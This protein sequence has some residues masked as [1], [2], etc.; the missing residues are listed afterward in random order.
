L[1][2]AKLIEDSL[3]NSDWITIF[4]LGNNDRTYTELPEWFQYLPMLRYVDI[5][6]WYISGNQFRG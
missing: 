5:H 6:G 3:K 1:P 4:A 2:N